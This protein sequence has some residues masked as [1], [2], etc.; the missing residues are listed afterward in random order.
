VKKKSR[1]SRPPRRA[2]PARRPGS[3]HARAAAPVAPAV[4]RTAA[5]AP[6]PAR[7][8]ATNAFHN[9]IPNS[10]YP[11]RPVGPVP[12]DRPRPRANNHNKRETLA[13]IL[14]AGLGKRMQSRWSKLLHSVAGRPVVR[15]V[16]EATRGAG[17]ARTVVVIG[18]QA[19]EVRRAVGDHDKRIAFAFQK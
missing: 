19:E 13:L 7:P 2:K 14:A 8:G 6:P 3:R 4:P 5:P 17:V 1:R 18:N 12:D 11:L 16:V 9:A 15:H 10:P